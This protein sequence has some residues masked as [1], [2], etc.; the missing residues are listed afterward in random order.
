MT[1]FFLGW[2]EGECMYHMGGH[3]NSEIVHSN[4]FSL[5]SES[6]LLDDASPTMGSPPPLRREVDFFLHGQRMEQ[7][8]NP[9]VRVDSSQSHGDCGS[10]AYHPT[11]CR[12]WWVDLQFRRASGD[13]P[14]VRPTPGRT[15]RLCC[16]HYTCN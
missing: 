4:P 1:Y 3:Y 2:Q 12:R 7:A 6:I 10:N 11:T 15:G 14:C 9:A 8:R 13:W 5:C 16:K